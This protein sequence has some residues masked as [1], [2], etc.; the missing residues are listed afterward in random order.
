MS[1]KLLGVFWASVLLAV[2]R[3]IAR[4]ISC[5]RLVLSGLLVPLLLIAAHG[6]HAQQ[7]PLTSNGDPTLAASNCMNAGYGSDMNRFSACWIMQMAS[8]QQREIGN[9]IIMNGNWA[10][11]GFCMAG[12]NLSPAGQAVAQCAL[13]VAYSNAPPQMLAT[14]AGPMGVNPETMRLAG[15]VAANADNF[16][17][18]AMCVGGQQ[19]TPEQHVFAEC[20]IETGLQ[21]YAFAACATGQLT[22]NEFQKCFTV[23]IGREGCFGNNNTIVQLVRA[24]WKGTAGP[25]SVLNRPGQIF[26]GPNSAFRDPAQIWG[27]P[28]SMFNNPG[29]IFGGPNSIVRNPAQIWGGPNSVVRNPDQL[30]GGSNSFFHKTLGFHF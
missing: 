21:P 29:Q 25:N 26:G 1:A 18:A 6:T 27:G 5:C 7:I 30:L 24:F 22:I 11:A 2:G 16:W 10:T 12:R 15:C 13:N 9:C 19:L 14:C 3:R 17:G 28:N 20:A 23:G 8:P 4:I